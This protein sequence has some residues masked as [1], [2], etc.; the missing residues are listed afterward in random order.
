MFSSASPLQKAQFYV[1]RADGKVVP[2]IAMDDLPNNIVV[3]DVPRLL[4]LDETAGMVSVGQ[5]QTRHTTHKVDL[6][7]SMKGPFVRDLD[8]VVKVDVD[9]ESKKE[10]E[11]ESKEFGENE[12]KDRGIIDLL[13]DIDDMSI[14][15]TTV[16]HAAAVSVP[17]PVVTKI[18]SRPQPASFTSALPLTPSATTFPATTSL[19]GNDVTAAKVSQN[20]LASKHATHPTGSGN[21]VNVSR[22]VNPPISFSI[23]EK[24]RASNPSTTLVDLTP[25]KTPNPVLS[26][27]HGKSL[28]SAAASGI[29]VYCSHWIRKGECDYVQQGCKFKH[30]M[31]QDLATLESIGCRDFP[32]WYRR[33]YGVGSL[34]AVPGSD[35]SKSRGERQQNVSINSRNWRASNMAQSIGG[36]KNS[37]VRSGASGENTVYGPANKPDTPRRRSSVLL[38]ALPRR[39]RTM[40][41]I[42]L[43]T[44]LAQ[45]AKSNRED[46]ERKAE[47]VACAARKARKSAIGTVSDVGGEQ[48]TSSSSSSDVSRS[49][50]SGSMVSGSKSVLTPLTASTTA[51]DAEGG[52]DAASLMATKRMITAGLGITPE[53][54]ASKSVGTGTTTSRQQTSSPSSTDKSARPA[55]RRRNGMDRRRGVRMA[56]VSSAGPTPEAVVGAD[57]GGGGGAVGRAKTLVDRLRAQQSAGASKTVGRGSVLEAKSTDMGGKAVEAGK[58]EMQV[59][60]RKVW[61]EYDHDD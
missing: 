48:S 5:H 4:N 9:D 32:D 57:G 34:L 13:H 7:E 43:E 42:Q 15:A 54:G 52:S 24:S 27:T 14:T 41:E 30:E 28:K 53:S 20:L 38:S 16:G 17:D 39:I 40:E 25:P 6:A 3:H 33:D 18:L 8:R 36:P 19:S 11:S 29:K 46:A 37:F 55:P 47:L 35:A 2:L 50:Q 51:S 59:V 45:I 10:V 1:T 23:H 49:T 12:N 61:E 31:P 26:T 21:W 60:P 44:S 58:I 56:S 22:Y